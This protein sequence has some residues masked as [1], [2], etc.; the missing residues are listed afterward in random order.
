MDSERVCVRH[1]CGRYPLR[2]DN[3]EANILEDGETVRIRLDDAEHPEFWLEMTL[4]VE[5]S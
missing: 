5:A 4:E 3:I 1:V 2:G